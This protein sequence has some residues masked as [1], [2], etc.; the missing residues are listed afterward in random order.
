VRRQA[1]WFKEN[2]PQINWFDAGK[3][4]VTEIETNIRRFLNV[5][6]DL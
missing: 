1:N 5:K 4:T 6:V 2:D 3:T